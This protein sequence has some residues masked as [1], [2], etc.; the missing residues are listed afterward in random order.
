MG[1]DHCG[2]MTTAEERGTAGLQDHT[3][4]SH[5]RTSRA[6]KGIQDLQQL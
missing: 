4:D 3:L 6:G 5:V 2:G 1:L